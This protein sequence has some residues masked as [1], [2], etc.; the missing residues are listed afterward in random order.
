MIH[1]ASVGASAL[2]K[3]AFLAA[4]GP[5]SRRLVLDLADTVRIRR[6]ESLFHAGEA[7]LDCFLIITGKVK[8]TRLA[9]RQPPPPPA[10]APHQRLTIAQR[11]QLAKNVTPQR[12]SLQWLMGTGDIF[13]ELSVFDQ[14]TRSSSAQAVSD[15]TMLR[16][17]GAELAQVVNTRPDV[18]SAMLAQLAT[19]LRRGDDHTAGLVLSDVPG[20]L[21]WLMLHL[22]ERFGDPDEPGWIT[23]DLTQR[24][25]AQFVGAS[26]ESVS[27]VLSDFEARG[28]I[29]TKPR[30][31]RVLA[32]DRLAA[33]ME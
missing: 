14:G 15:A 26:R 7:A 25:I 30:R 24:E 27:K 12:E 20:R 22:Q 9:K 8:L 6:G 31:V 21:A 1:Q 4:L 29:E 28:L 10:P 2:D 13:G 32:A 5:E 19:R 16:F 33:R 18:S 17:E 11:R 3:V 23:H